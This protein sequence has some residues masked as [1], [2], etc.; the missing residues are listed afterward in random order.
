MCKSP[1]H[2]LIGRSE[3]EC[4]ATLKIART[5]LQNGIDRSTVMKMTGLTGVD[6]PLIPLSWHSLSGHQRILVGQGGTR[7]RLC[8]PSTTIKQL[9]HPRHVPGQTHCQWIYLLAAVVKSGIKVGSR[10]INTVYAYTERYSIPAGPFSIAQQTL[11]PAHILRCFQGVS[12]PEQVI[13][14]RQLT[15]E[16][17]PKVIELTGQLCANTQMAALLQHPLDI[18][19]D[20]ARETSLLQRGCQPA[21]QKEIFLCR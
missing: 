20:I 21:G 2:T 5:M 7:L 19:S 11:V 13:L 6:P 18:W 4:Q 9:H 17:T 12:Q 15:G 1:E 10:E 14:F 16:G 8:L 3:S